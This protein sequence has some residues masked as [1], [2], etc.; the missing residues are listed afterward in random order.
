MP[1]RARGDGMQAEEQALETL[2]ATAGE[3]RQAGLVAELRDA[4]AALAGRRFN[5]AV[6]GQFKRGKSTLIN[7]LLDRDLLPADVAPI[8]SAITIVEHGQRERAWVHFSDGGETEAG[9]DEVHLFVSEEE[10][11]GNRKGVRVARI[12]LPSPLL[13]TG[14]RL[15]DT[16]GVGSVFAAN[17]EVTRAF[18][19]RIDVGVVVL[20]SDPPI[21]GDELALVKATAPTVGHLC[22]VLNKSDRV[23]EATRLKAEAFTR[24]VL[25]EALGHD[26][27]TLLHASARTALRE[28][29][30]PGV[31]ALRDELSGLAHDSGTELARASAARA[32][33]HVAGHLLRQLDLEHAALTAPLA[34][35]D[36][37][38]AE[39]RAAMRDVDDLAIAALARTKSALSYDWQRWQSEKDEFL[40]QAQGRVQ[41]ELEAELAQDGAA[42]RSRTRAAARA[43]ALEHAR[44]LVDEWH[45]RAR[46]ELARRREAWLARTMEE[47][48]RLLARVADA[49]SAAFG[50]P[51]ARFEPEA[52]TVEDEP[53]AFEFFEGV[54]F[55][56]PAA[57]TVPLVDALLPRRAVLGRA[58]TRASRLVREWLERN[59]NEVD[60]RL[61]A[62]LDALAKQLDVAL[63]ARLDGVRQEVLDAVETG[64]RRRQEG[65]VAIRAELDALA[66]QR[67]RVFAAIA[68]L[69][70]A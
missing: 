56:D 11:P 63:R 28:G 45:E 19:S 47:T 6:M 25:G 1:G 21:S 32:A 60:Q 70:P 61:V 9:L 36:R 52:I 7:A 18:V 15:I 33:R 43:L 34:E 8:T 23:R 58:A 30:D 4:R 50:T 40:K 39:F 44:T 37:R 10:N 66:H 27:G 14:I 59:L 17:S 5:V 55:L 31:A 57:I 62:R 29:S 69:E 53:I 2:A 65:E 24:R 67:K 20:G 42:S 13:A 26:P 46:A 51:V 41:A 38:I 35:L 48:G 12:A 49:A 68:S 54:L 22:F 64:R 16:P 3:R